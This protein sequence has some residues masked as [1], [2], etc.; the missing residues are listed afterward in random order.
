MGP[1]CTRGDL[2]RYLCMRGSVL[3]CS[4]RLKLQEVGGIHDYDIQDWLSRYVDFGRSAESHGSA[5]LECNW[6]WLGRT[7]WSR[8]KTYTWDPYA[9]YPCSPHTNIM[10]HVLESVVSAYVLGT[11]H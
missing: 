7:R 1:R 3:M 10:I 11:N 5:I 6:R 4:V 2:R 8:G 9:A